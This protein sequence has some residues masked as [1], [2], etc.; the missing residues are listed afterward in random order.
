MVEDAA[1]LVERAQAH[2][3]K[4]LVRLSALG[5]DY[6]RKITLGRVHGEVE[7]ILRGSGIDC[8]FLRP[9]SFMQ[10]FVTYWGD[11]IRRQNAFYIPQGQG[12]VS[13]ID[14]RDI[15][16]VA[17]VALTQDGHAGK[18]YELTGPEALSNYDIAKTL[19]AVLG[20]E[21]S[22]RDIPPEDA[23]GALIAQGMN[24]WMVKVILELFEMSASDEAAEVTGDVERLIGRPPIRFE[25]FARD[26]SHAFS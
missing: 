14:A 20:R 10:N 3:V 22:Y 19:S 5:V 13:I 11:S 18:S 24:E 26:F 2:G 15:A 1:L 6:P 21:I 23:R 9:N 17:V 8:T 25:D 7:R 16:D 4:H 12:R